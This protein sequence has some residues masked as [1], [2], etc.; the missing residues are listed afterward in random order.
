MRMRKEGKGLRVNEEDFQFS[1]DMEMMKTFV[2]HSHKTENSS[3]ISTKVAVKKDADEMGL[4]FYLFC[5][6]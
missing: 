2:H 4:K 1:L 5:L 6:I 3:A